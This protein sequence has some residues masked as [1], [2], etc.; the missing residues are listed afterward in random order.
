MKSI[1]NCSLVFGSL[2]IP[3]RLFSAVKQSHP[4]FEMVD[5]RDMSK[6]HISRYNEKTGEIVP[7]EFLGKAFNLDGSLVPVD[8][9][10]VLSVLPEQS[11]RVEFTHFC[12][13]TSIPAV[14]FDTF[15]FLLPEASSAKNYAIILQYLQTLNICGIAQC[16]FRNLSALFVISAH[17]GCIVLHKI[18][19]PSCFIAFEA[20][21][22]P[23]V[24]DEDLNVEKDILTFFNAHLRPF[25]PD[26]YADTFSESLRCALR[27]NASCN[28]ATATR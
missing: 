3:V 20:P 14:Y 10:L 26:D 28:N 22:L 7:K 1:W 2:D 19:F 24:T 25:N 17:H 15:Y 6:I 5:S 21:A 11:N 4:G 13:F 23:A 12:P 27:Q 8:P 9:A 16:L 18:R